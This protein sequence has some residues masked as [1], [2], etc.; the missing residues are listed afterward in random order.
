MHGHEQEA[1]HWELLKSK[2]QAKFPNYKVHTLNI[3]GVGE[4]YLLNSFTSVRQNLYFIRDQWKKKFGQ[5]I[6][7]SDETIFIG[8]SLGGMI[9][10]EWATQFPKELSKLILINTSIGGVCP[11]YERYQFKNVFP[12]IKY[13]L[14]SDH[15]KKNEILY[16]LTQHDLQLKSKWVSNWNAI[17]IDA[18]IHWKNTLKQLFAAIVFR[19]QKLNLEIPTLIIS[20][21][22]DKFISSKC[23]EKMA[24]YWGIKHHEHSSAGHHIYI[25]DPTWLLDRW[26]EFI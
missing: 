20:S 3:P 13:L 25:D 19:D 14:T 18:P 5:S 11:I 10:L 15:R 4:W 6:H 21:T 8:E 1:R 22:K 9:G 16:D 7:N 2:I 24:Q 26:A 23:S 17:S 12:F